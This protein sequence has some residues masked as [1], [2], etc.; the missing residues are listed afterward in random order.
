MPAANV[1]LEIQALRAAAVLS[2]VVYHLWPNRLPGGFVGVDVFFAISGYLITGHLLREGETTGTVR[3]VRFWARRVRRLLPASLLVL[4][5]TSVGVLAFVPR[6]YWSQFADGVLGSTLYVQNWVLAAQSVDYLAADN[7]PTPVQHFWS[8]S[9]EEQFYFVWP[10]LVVIALVLARRTGVTSR[11]TVLAALAVVFVASLVASVWLTATDPGLAYFATYTRAWEFAAGGILAVVLPKAVDLSGRRRAVLSWAGWG[12]IA[13][14]LL[15]FSGAT[16][17]PSYTAV[18]PIVGALLVIAAGVPTTASNSGTSWSPSGIMT[19]GPVQTIGD[20]SYSI[21]LWHWPLIVILPFITGRSLSTSDKVAV[22]V[23]SV[24]LAM[25]TRWLVEGPGQRAFRNATPRRQTARTFGSLGI[26]M[27]LVAAVPIGTI[28]VTQ[29]E[30]VASAAQ[31]AERASND[32]TCF[33]ASALNTASCDAHPDA[34]QLLPSRAALF[35]DTGKAFEC[36]R[37]E[38][39]PSIKTCSFGSNA[40]G[41]PRIALVGDSHGAMLIPGLAEQAAKRGWHLDTYVG[42]NG[43]W[44]S[45]GSLATA[46]DRTYAEQLQSAL[47]GGSY[48][49]ILSTS[50]RYSGASASKVNQVTKSVREVWADVQA[51]GSKVAVIRDNPQITTGALQCVTNAASSTTDFGACRVSRSSGLGGTDWGVVAAR[52]TAVPVIDMERYFCAGDSCPVVIGGVIVYRDEH[53]ITATFSKTLAPMLADA[54]A[55]QLK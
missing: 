25:V 54:I 7:V 13:L 3:I 50:H 44:Q 46:A 51:H 49:L 4:V 55:A 5:A 45:R 1:R 41:A 14:S 26:A 18:I 11:R 43:V 42:Y 22:L 10:V 20:L 28:Y 23:L 37:A 17:F 33:G 31:A 27:I 19:F 48:D 38:G 8:L 6:S 40:P 52:G 34:D 47:D 53:H 2:V 12:I 39:K 9:V 16:P 36:Y 24:V 29:R 15:Q 21:Y 35:D 30:N 32:A